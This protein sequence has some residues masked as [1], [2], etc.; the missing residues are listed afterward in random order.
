MNSQIYIY[1]LFA[2]AIAAVA[3]APLAQEPA[4][5]IHA[6]EGDTIVSWGKYHSKTTFFSGYDA[7]SHGANS[8][9]RL[10][11]NTSKANG[12]KLSAELKARSQTRWT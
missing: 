4:T 11:N 3:A 7:G 12:G 8:S 10:R 1:T 9:S 6:D 2:A 5:A